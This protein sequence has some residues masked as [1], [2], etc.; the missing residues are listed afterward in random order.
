MAAPL[1][2]AAACQRVADMRATVPNQLA[3]R[4]TEHLQQCRPTTRTSESPA[5]IDTKPE[6][7]AQHAEGQQLTASA[8]GSSNQADNGLAHQTAEEENG[9]STSAFSPAPADLHNMYAAAVQ[10]M[11][12]LR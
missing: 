7:G 12:A 8:P 1:Q 11:P 4:L 9:M 5:V 3:Q 6:A 2:V 10:R